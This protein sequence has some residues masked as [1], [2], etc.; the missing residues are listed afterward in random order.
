MAELKMEPRSEREVVEVDVAIVVQK[1]G[2]S[3]GLR[4]ID[5][6]GR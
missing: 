3:V 2:W 1:K 4:A 5:A 6:M